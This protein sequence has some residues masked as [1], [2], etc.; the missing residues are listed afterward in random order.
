MF[1]NHLFQLKGQRWNGVN[2]ARVRKT[3]R[4]PRFARL[5]IAARWKWKRRNVKLDPQ[6]SFSLSKSCKSFNVYP[7]D[8]SWGAWTP[9]TSCSKTCDWG[10][11]V[12]KRECSPPQQGGEPCEGEPTQTEDCRAKNCPGMLEVL[13]SDHPSTQWM[14]NGLSGVGGARAWAVV[15]RQAGAEVGLALLLLS[16]AGPVGGRTWRLRSAA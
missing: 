10:L 1:S 14:V 11:R 3:E 9:W 13:N 5:L 7:V 15:E 2:G 12:R 4:G 16:M 8:G 6:V